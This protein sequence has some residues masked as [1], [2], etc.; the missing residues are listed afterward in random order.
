M[1]LGYMRSHGLSRGQ[2]SQKQMYESLWVVSNRDMPAVH[3]YELAVM[4][5]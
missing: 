1:H 3:P 2:I 4:K 5:G